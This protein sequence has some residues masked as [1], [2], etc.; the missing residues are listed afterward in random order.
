MNPAVLT[1]FALAISADGQEPAYPGMAGQPD[2]AK[3]GKGPG[4]SL[5]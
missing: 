4:S 3:G 1:A 5:Y 2:V